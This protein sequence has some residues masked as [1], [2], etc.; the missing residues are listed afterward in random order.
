M[1][2]PYTLL[3]GNLIVEDQDSIFVYWT[4]KGEEG[5][6]TIQKGHAVDAE[7]SSDSFDVEANERKICKAI[8]EWL[9]GQ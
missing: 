1:S 6:S 9:K 4:Y 5:D 2:Y 7:G 3:G 8:T